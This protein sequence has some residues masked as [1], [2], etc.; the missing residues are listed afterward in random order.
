MVRQPRTLSGW[1]CWLLRG[2]DL[3]AG[4]GRRGGGGRR[5]GGGAAGLEAVWERELS[6]AEEWWRWSTGCRA[7]LRAG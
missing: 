7:A 4:G 2:L 5:V 3:W 6:A 1:E